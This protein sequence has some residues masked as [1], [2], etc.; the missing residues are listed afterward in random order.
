MASRPH[1]ENQ[2]LIITHTFLNSQVSSYQAEPNK[3]DAILMKDSNCKNVAW[4]DSMDQK[5]VNDDSTNDLV[6]QE[7]V[8][9]VKN[10]REENNA[11]G[12][13][14][15]TCDPF[16]AECFPPSADQADQQAND[17]NADGSK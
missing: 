9:P 11:K 6:N 13:M 16:Y 12:I 3:T 14:K 2:E 4:V 15:V 1:L 5:L 17:S 7:Q 10:H 8:L